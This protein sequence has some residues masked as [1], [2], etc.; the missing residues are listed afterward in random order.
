[1]ENMKKMN[2][3]LLL[4]VFVVVFSIM[5]IGVFIVEKSVVGIIVSIVFVCVVMGGGFILKKKMCE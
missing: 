3:F 4:F 2:W 1:M 5:L